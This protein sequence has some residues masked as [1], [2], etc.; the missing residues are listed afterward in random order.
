MRHA[1]TLIEMLVVISIIA[2][3]SAVLIPAVTSAMGSADQAKDQ[4][5][6]GNIAK[7]LLA[8]R[9]NIG[10]PTSQVFPKRILDLADPAKGGPLE[11]EVRIFVSPVDVSE[12]RDPTLGTGDLFDSGYADWAPTIHESGCSYGYE[13]SDT[14]MPSSWTFPTAQPNNPPP[15]EPSWA[16]YK[17]AQKKFGN[18]DENGHPTSFSEDA[19]P[20]LRCWYH[21]EWD[22]SN[23]Y[24]EKRVLN[25]AWSTS[26]YWSI[27]YWEH[28]ANPDQIPNRQ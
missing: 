17:R 2:L 20:V 4:S 15:S 8:W 19:I 1:F 27:P 13:C 24:N 18:S 6:M 10:K 23:D 14:A 21:G 26:V 9:A 22:G 3:L 11:G 28:Q 16:D 5:Q 12:G 7:A 25:A